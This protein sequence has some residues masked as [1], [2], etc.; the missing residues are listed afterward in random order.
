M[1]MLTLGTTNG[2]GLDTARRY[3]NGATADADD[4][5]VDVVRAP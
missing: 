1:T 4:R 3:P 5:L 2:E